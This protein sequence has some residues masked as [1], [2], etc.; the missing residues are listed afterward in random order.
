MSNTP[1]LARPFAPKGEDLKALVD[2]YN[3]KGKLPTIYVKCT[4][5]NDNIT[6]FGSNLDRRVEAYGGIE[7]LLTKIIKK[8]KLKELKA[9]GVIISDMP[10][11]KSPT[12]KPKTPEEI[13]AMIAE[14]NNQKAQMTTPTAEVTVTE[15]PAETETEIT[16]DTEEHVAAVNG[17]NKKNRR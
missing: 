7:N 1:T 12:R 14:L 11:R 13:D 3:T 17:N 5:S 2:H 10:A 4:V 9:K 15:Q 6:C 8:D 16:A